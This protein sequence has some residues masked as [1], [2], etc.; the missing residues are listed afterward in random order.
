MLDTCD[1]ETLCFNGE[2]FFII[3]SEH[4]E[5]LLEA[6]EAFQ[7]V[8]REM[9]TSGDRQMMRMHRYHFRSNGKKASTPMNY[10]DRYNFS[11]WD[12]MVQRGPI[13]WLPEGTKFLNLEQNPNLYHFASFFM[14]AWSDVVEDPE[15]SLYFVNSDE[16][17][18]TPWKNMLLSELVSR[19]TGLLSEEELE[20]LL[21]S[22]QHR[23]SAVD[24]PKRPILLRNHLRPSDESNTCNGNV[25]RAQMPYS[26]CARSARTFSYRQ[27]VLGGWRDHATL[28]ESLGVEERGWGDRF[29]SPR[30][31]LVDRQAGSQSTRKLRD[32]DK[33][34]ETL[35]Q[36][37]TYLNVTVRYVPGMPPNPREQVELM[38]DTDVLIMVHGAGLTNGM[39]LSQNA[40]V[41]ELFPFGFVQNDHYREMLGK[42]G[43]FY[44]AVHGVFSERFEKELLVSQQKCA[45]LAKRKDYIRRRSHSDDSNTCFH[46]VWKHADVEVDDEDLFEAVLEAV[47]QLPNY[48]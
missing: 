16:K 48:G 44:R 47:L 4:E 7:P 21:D 19:A 13:E 43:I 8:P 41:V 15:G 23:E 42:P 5:D 6:I 10:L 24:K 40:A 11:S 26:I 17:C 29:Q 20:V 32:P 12:Q 34:L 38:G 30:V 33:I 39:F 18:L 25:W 31:T 27:N 14:P 22:M 9:S 36:L 1:Y 45:Q 37:P 2:Q 46:N 35:E 28:R 3:A